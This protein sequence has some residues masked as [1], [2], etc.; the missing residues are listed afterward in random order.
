MKKMVVE[1]DKKGQ[2]AIFV[3]LGVALVVVLLILF[4]G[5][6]NFTSIFLGKSPVQKMEECVSGPLE[7]GLELVR[8]QGGSIDPE[9]YYL[10][11]DR[12]IDYICFTDQSFQKCVMQ[13]PLLKESIENELMDYIKEDVVRCLED[14]RDALNRGTTSVTFKDPKVEVSLVP[15][16]VIVVTELDLKIV[17]GETS[18]SYKSIRTDVNSKLYDFVFVA[19]DIANNEVEYGD[20]TVD[21]YSF[22]DK[23]LKVEKIKQ[24]DETT[25]YILSDRGSDEQFYFAI[26]SVPI[27]PGWI[28]GE[29]FE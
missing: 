29:L 1:M 10:Y 19:A 2:I 26:K 22:L 13:K 3:I 20:A 11:K 24:G 9:N 7:S 27:P 14:E 25:V 8:N 6:K 12:K 18:E 16:D 5:N 23:S 4:S 17:K 15:N 28:D 21:K